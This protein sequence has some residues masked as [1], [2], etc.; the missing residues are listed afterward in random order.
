MSAGTSSRTCLGWPFQGY[1]LRA[2]QLLCTRALQPQTGPCKGEMRADRFPPMR[3][4]AA[5]PP[6]P[7]AKQAPQG[8][9]KPLSE[10]C[11]AGETEAQWVR[12]LQKALC[13][14]RRH[15]LLPVLGS[16]YHTA[17]PDLLVVTLADLTSSVGENL[18]RT[19]QR[20]PGARAPAEG[21]ASKTQGWAFNF[22]GTF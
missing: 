7:D 3:R 17:L 1:P 4:E 13:G 18:T 19:L 11:A 6:F 14:G 9:S 20:C 16:C 10:E 15:L 22:W 2:H 8:I 12:G 5:T 21:S